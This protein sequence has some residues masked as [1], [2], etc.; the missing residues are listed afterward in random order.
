MKTAKSYRDLI[1]WQK[2]MQLVTD[3]YLVTNKMPYKEQFNLVSQL[4][5]ASVSIPSNIA[6]GFGRRSR[7]EFIRFLNISSGSL[8]ELQTEIEIA[9]NIQLIDKE[10]F[11]DIYSR[12]S[13]IDK[14]LRSLI[15]KTR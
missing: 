5:R 14:M 13:E 10:Q 12:T 2:S 3:I 15:M 4:N 7:K 11:D 6:E 1:V 9:F 8:F